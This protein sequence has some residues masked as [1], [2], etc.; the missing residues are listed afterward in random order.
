MSALFPV[1]ILCLIVVFQVFAIRKFA[2]KNLEY[3]R[4]FSKSTSVVGDEIEMV[5]T[6]RNR[7][8]LPL[9]LLCVETKAPLWLKF[10]AKKE[11]DIKARMFHRSLFTLGPYREIIR[12]HPLT[13]L[14]RGYYDMGSVSMTVTDLMGNTSVCKAQNVGAKLLVYPR[15]LSDDEW[16][17][18]A[19]RWQGDMLV[20]R[21]I[22]PDPFLISGVR[23]WR[24]GDC[25]RDVHWPGTARTGQIQVKTHEFTA[26]EKLLVILN[27]QIRANQWDKLNDDEKLTLEYGLSLAATLCRTALTAGAEAGFAADFPQD[28]G[29]EATV[30]LPASYPGREEDLLAAIA[31][32]KTEH[33]SSFI[34]WLDVFTQLKDTNI[35]IL[36][37]Y[38]DDELTEKVKA[39]AV[40]GNS[41]SVLLMDSDMIGRF[42]Q[43]LKE[44]VYGQ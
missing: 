34:K 23:P 37:A 11:L 1:V 44:A 15:Y 38:E 2:F 19:S 6:I 33:L 17:A 40:N 18:P 24:T 14:K 10:K 31:H 3:S 4:K 43:Q 7:K 28:D 35:V 8:L 22:A 29:T 41:A 39:L 30:L 9:P 25:L 42:S 12:R 5:E 32:I 27:H 13:L 21:W 16:I 36:S 26:D 20:R